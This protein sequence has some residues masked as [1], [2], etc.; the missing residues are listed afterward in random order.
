[1][2]QPSVH[3]QRAKTARD[4]SELLTLLLQRVE[5]AKLPT[6]ALETLCAEVHLLSTT[7]GDFKLQVARELAVRERP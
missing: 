2:E 1:M 7:L 5:V 4:A 3:T 6:E